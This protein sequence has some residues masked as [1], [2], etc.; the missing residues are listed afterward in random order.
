MTGSTAKDMKTAAVDVA[1]EH[2][3]GSANAIQVKEKGQG[4]MG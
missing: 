3:E 4:W 1:L 2:L